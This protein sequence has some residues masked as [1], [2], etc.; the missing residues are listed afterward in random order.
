MPAWRTAS[1]ATGIDDILTP[2]AGLDLMRFEKPDWHKRYLPPVH[3]A[4]SIYPKMTEVTAVNSVVC[5]L[6]MEKPQRNFRE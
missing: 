3:N 5:G 6:E 4:G 2:C 1:A